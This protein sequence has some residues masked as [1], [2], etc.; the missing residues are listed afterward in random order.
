[1]YTGCAP[2]ATMFSEKGGERD[3]RGVK[4]RYGNSKNTYNN[5]R[6]GKRT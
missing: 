1:M 4:F 5:N 2:F 6:T 3:F